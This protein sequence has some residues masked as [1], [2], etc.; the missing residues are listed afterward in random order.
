M[1]AAVCVPIPGTLVSADSDACQTAD[2]DPNRARS[3]RTRAPPTPDTRDSPIN[4]RRSLSG[5]V[6]GDG[7]SGNGNCIAAGL[8]WDER[9]KIGVLA[10]N[11]YGAGTRHIG[12]VSVNW[13]RPSLARPS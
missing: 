11:R 3:A 8:Q 13:K 2:A 4:A 5:S 12:N 1:A 7:T 6:D 10:P 9:R